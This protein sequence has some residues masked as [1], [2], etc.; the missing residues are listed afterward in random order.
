MSAAVI[1]TGPLLGVESDTTYSFC[2]L[3]PDS[4]EHAAVLLGDE[5]SEATPAFSRCGFTFW[6]ATHDIDPP[7]GRA[8][9][10]HTYQI[11]ADG[12]VAS[13]EYGNDGWSF[14]VPGRDEPIRIAYGSC[15]GVAK[16]MGAGTLS[17]MYDLWGRMQTK[18][19]R[20]PYSLLLL[21]GD[22]VYCDKVWDIDELADFPTLSYDEQCRAAAKG[23]LADALDDFY[24]H[25]IYR[26]RWSDPRMRAMM[27]S[28]PSIMMWDDH[29]IFDGWGSHPD[30][31]RQSATYQE[32]FAA[33]KWYFEAFQVRTLENSALLRDD[34]THYSMHVRFRGHDIFALDN[35][36]ERT[37]DTIMEPE[38][39]EEV[40]ARLHDCP[41]G[42]HVLL[43]SAVPVVYR[44]FAVA[45]T[46][47]AATPWREQLEDDVLDHWRAERHQG[48]R[49]KLIENLVESAGRRDGRTLIL[50]GDVHV[51]AFGV[52]TASNGATVHQF[53]S[54][55][56]VHP[57][58]GLA[59]WMGILAVSNDD[60]EHLGDDGSIRTRLLKI[61]GGGE[62]IKEQNYL[63]L[64]P[65]SDGKLWA[66]WECKSGKRPL[67]AIA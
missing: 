34:G 30:L 55:G 22:Q 64:E 26:I 13:D 15:N 37:I 12:Q 32:I 59:G 49:L 24:L 8:G 3:T 45:E 4:V 14:Y 9:G 16:S 5:R 39:W 53:I 7:A 35:R 42:N 40:K 38:H 2:F 48:E 62:Y 61:P 58:P 21:G 1:D 28:I 50:S 36:S 57:W 47:M 56:I 66:A 18:H 33:A 67:V 27:A 23:G 65:G 17:E 44:D 10:Q 43:M 52:I 60:P 11:E 41:P 54:S 63:S 19:E 20:E 51:G 6:R 25:T 31:L 46:M 29:D